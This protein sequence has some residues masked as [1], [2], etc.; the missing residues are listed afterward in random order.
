MVATHPAT[1]VLVYDWQ[2]GEFAKRLGGV[3][4]PSRDSLVVAIELNRR[5]VCYDADA[6]EHDPTGEGFEWFCQMAFEVGGITPGRKLV[7]VDECQDLIDPWNMPEALGDLLSRGRRRQIDTCIVGRSA[8][9]L[10]T[11]ARDQVSELYVFRCIDENSLKYPKSV[12]LDPERVK[13]LKDTE[14]I[15]KDMRTGDQ[16]ELELFGKESNGSVVQ[17]T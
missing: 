8:N 14:F 13:A 11:E 16:N 10:Q 3:L 2:G 17:S 15:H 5:I 4:C 12:G 9:S 7:V 6:G 1:L